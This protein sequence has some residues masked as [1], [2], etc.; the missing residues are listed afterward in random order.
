MGERSLGGGGDA[1]ATSCRRTRL[2]E[3]R[4]LDRKGRVHW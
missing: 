3:R 2:G 4:D 1:Q